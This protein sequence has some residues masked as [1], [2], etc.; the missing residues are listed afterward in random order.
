MRVL[1][2]GKVAAIA[3]SAFV[4]A[5]ALTGCGAATSAAPAGGGASSSGSTS[6]QAVQ[7]DSPESDTGGTEAATAAD[8]SNGEGDA[9]V[10]SGTGDATRA[11]SSSDATKSFDASV[12]SRSGYRVFHVRTA[13]FQFDL[14]AYWRGKVEWFEER[15]P[16]GRIEVSICPIGMS[17][18]TS[19]GDYEYALVTVNS[20]DANVPA[21]GGDIG[22]GLVAHADGSDKDVV[23]YQKNWIFLGRE[24]G[25]DAGAGSR[26]YTKSELDKLIGLATGGKLDYDDCKYESNNMACLDYNTSQFDGKIKVGSFSVPSTPAKTAN[27]Y[28]MPDTDL[29]TYNA[30][31]WNGMDN[32]ELFIV[33]NEIFARHG[34]GFKSQELRDHF[35]KQAWYKETI[36]A[37]TYDT[38]ILSSV[39]KENANAILEVEKQRNSPYV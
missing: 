6:G 2:K 29:V 32:H 7:S 19:S 10:A 11:F 21:E 30:R 1:K 18:R 25:P 14:P 33:R 35:G 36:D 4:L 5:V 28:A 9:S 34:C 39:E 27:E 24:K 37:G 3:V 23:A 16:N 8:D 17:D 15:L 22:G 31:I 12:S 13:D 38:S 20:T 26:T